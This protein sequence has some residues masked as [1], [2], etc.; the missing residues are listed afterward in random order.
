[1]GT[2]THPR[3]AGLGAGTQGASEPG[4]APWIK[5]LAASR[6]RSASDLA[7]CLQGMNPPRPMRS[8]P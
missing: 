7:R 6:L 8:H 4:V 2:E 5:S 3:P 1:M